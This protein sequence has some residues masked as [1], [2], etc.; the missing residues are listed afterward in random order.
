MGR[1]D[2]L[3]PVPLAHGVDLRLWLRL[4]PTRCRRLRLSLVFGLRLRLDWRRRT[5]R[6]LDDGFLCDVHVRSPLWHALFARRGTHVVIPLFG[7]AV[8]DPTRQRS[9]LES[10]WLSRF[11]RKAAA[12]SGKQEEQ[13]K[14]LP[15][16]ALVRQEIGLATS[17]AIASGRLH[18]SVIIYAA[19][20]NDGERVE[21]ACVV[22]GRRGVPTCGIRLR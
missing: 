12:G 22:R 14:I 15:R 20:C 17:S 18:N 10:L 3:P 7:M 9:A 2:P 13:S 16:S 19:R 4:T 6:W 8:A 11:P 1:G 21:R 5:L